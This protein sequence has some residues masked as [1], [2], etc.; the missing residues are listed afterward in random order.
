MKWIILFIV[1]CVT[2]MFC[3]E[4]YAQDDYD[5]EEEEEVEAT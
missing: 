5:D 3:Y 1:T 2:I 4:Y